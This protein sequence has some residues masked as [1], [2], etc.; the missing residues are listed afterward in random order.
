MTEHASTRR[1]LLAAG[2]AGAVSLAAGRTPAAAAPPSKQPAGT[3]RPPI[4]LTTYMFKHY[5]LGQTIE[6]AQRVA[7]DRICL[8]SN[9]LPLG[10][11]PQQIGAVIEKV[12]AAGLKI[13]GGGVISM[14]N[15]QQ[16]DRAMAYSRAAGFQLISI[17]IRPDLLGYL[18]RRLRKHDIR[19][20]IHNHGPEDRHWPTPLAIY[21]K[22]EKLDKRI[23]ICHDTGHTQRAGVDA[24]QATL[25]TG[26][27]ILDLHLKDVDAAQRQG[28]ST[29]LGRGVVDIAGV[30]RA[31]AKIGYAGVVGVEYEKHMKDLLPGL[32]ECVG[33]ARGALDALGRKA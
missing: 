14:G 33:Y 26:D 25:K 9:L 30:L 27:R 18:E 17:S 4:G 3:Q 20:A 19:A 11:A 23:G 8:R 2:G 5:T 1:E 32:A 31:L 28:H 21:E 7:V 22:I 10:S 29:E 15:E 13:Y 12:K 6:M 24:V 16:V